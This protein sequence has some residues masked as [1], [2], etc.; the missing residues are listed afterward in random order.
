MNPWSI[1]LTTAILAA[2]VAFVVSAVIHVMCLVIQRFTKEE[3]AP[4][5][6]AI[7][8]EEEKVDH[9]AEIAVAIAAARAFAGRTS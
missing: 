9:D 3:P 8:A 2:V 5:M 7:P 4:A 1:I 6:E